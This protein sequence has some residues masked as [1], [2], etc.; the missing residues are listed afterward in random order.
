MSPANDD[1]VRKESRKVDMRNV[2]VRHP[3]RSE[4]S[5]YANYVEVQSVLWE[6]RASFFE[7]TED[8]EGNL[9]REKKVSVVMAPQCAERVVVLLAGAI[10]G[11]LDGE[12]KEALEWAQQAL[13][14]R[15][16]REQQEE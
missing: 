7:V 9:V 4:G 11:N 5:T 3:E 6:V 16:L 2:P 15:I 1:P 8:E 14:E 10:S 13:A 12:E